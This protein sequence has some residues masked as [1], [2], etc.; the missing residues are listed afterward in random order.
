MARQVRKPRTE[1]KIYS[2]E[3]PLKTTEMHV[4]DNGNSIIVSGRRFKRIVLDS[5]LSKTKPNDVV[6][7]LEL[8]DD[9]QTDET[10][11]LPD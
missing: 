4:S 7:D 9:Q 6:E 5:C 1:P 3:P 11:S 2:T 8:I 10:Q